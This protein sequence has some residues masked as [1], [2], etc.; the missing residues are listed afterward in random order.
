MGQSTPKRWIAVGLLGTV[1]MG[2][3]AENWSTP[4]FAST[5]RKTY[6]TSAYAIQQE[7]TAGLKA[8]ATSMTIKYKGPTKKLENLLKQ[9]MEGALESDPYTKYVVEG[10]T[11]T[12]RGTT[13]MAKIDLNVEY[14]ETAENTRYVDNQASEILNR[15]ITPGMNG[16]QRVKAIHDYVVLNLEYDK[17]LKKYTAYEALKTGEAVC[18]GYSLL[19]YKLLKGAGIENRIVEGVAGGQLHAWNLV[20]LENRWYHLDTTWNDPLSA[21]KD[22]IRYDYYLRTD[23]ELRKDHHWTASRYPAAPTPYRHAL[24][25]LA[26]RGG[27]GAEVYR[28]L[29]RQLG[30]ELYNPDAA[31]RTAAE[32]KEKVGQEL[33]AGGLTVTVRYAGSEDLL[34]ENLGTLY[35]LSIDHIKYLAEPLEGTGDLRVEIHWETD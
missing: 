29:E 5:D 31:V 1:L 22:R 23:A 21:P 17:D 6:V 32:L 30:F 10:Y 20:K 2:S 12:W 14:R 13:G 27:D 24:R 19:T 11:Y 7:M 28:K 8:R 16:H 33:R 3:A 9:A 15:I 4:V 34:V 25:E 35:D 18:Q 26:D